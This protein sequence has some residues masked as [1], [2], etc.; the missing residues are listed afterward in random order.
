[1]NISISNQGISKQKSL[2][3]K[4]G[5]ASMRNI[6]IWNYFIFLVIEQGFGENIEG[7][8]CM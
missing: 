7:Y 8:S 3:M 2:D 5:I 4:K 1:M 6:D